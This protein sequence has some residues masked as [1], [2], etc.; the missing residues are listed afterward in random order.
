MS[1]VYALVVNFEL[2]DRLLAS[3][4]YYHYKLQVEDNN[5][6]FLRL[7]GCVSMYLDTTLHILHSFVQFN[8]NITILKQ[9]AV[10][11]MLVMY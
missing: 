3:F 9:K 8:F 11:R 6:I 1:A 4:P 10:C 5:S 7:V 2:V